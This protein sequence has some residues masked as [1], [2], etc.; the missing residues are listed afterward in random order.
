M[1]NELANAPQDRDSW[2]VTQPLACVGCGGIHG[3]VN[4]GI[5]CLQHRVR[6]LRTENATLARE[7][8]T[9]AEER[10]ALMAEVSPLRKLRAGVALL[11]KRILP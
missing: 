2:K 6:T 1:S 3:S 4:A 8:A 10:A 5:L 9:L 11:P 7:S